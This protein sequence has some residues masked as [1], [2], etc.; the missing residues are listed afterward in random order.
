MIA[1]SIVKSRY[2]ITGGLVAGAVTSGVLAGAGLGLAPTANAT[3][4]SAFGIGNSANCTSTLFSVALAIGDGASAHADV[5][6]GASFAVGA[7]AA[8][9][10]SGAFTLATA[11]GGIAPPR[12]PTVCSASP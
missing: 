10:T 11:T 12:G 7:G 4:A 6:F 8:A 9:T 2:K 5:F 3:C 1:L